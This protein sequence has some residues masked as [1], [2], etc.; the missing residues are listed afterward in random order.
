MTLRTVGQSL[1]RVD[2]VEKVTGR[3]RYCGDLLI[4]GM[5]YAHLV[6]SPHAH[7]HVL[8]IDTAQA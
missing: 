6:R 4:P 2:A 1:A 5:A 8:R 3:A 7:A